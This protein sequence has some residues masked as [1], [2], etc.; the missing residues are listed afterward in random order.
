MIQESKFPVLQS[1]K[2]WY[3]KTL[4]TPILSGNDSV[5]YSYDKTVSEK[6][7]ITLEQ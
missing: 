6:H 2:Q 3:Q 5:N 7:K 4:S 1:A